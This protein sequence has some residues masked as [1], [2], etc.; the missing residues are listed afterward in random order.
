MSVG[1]SAAAAQLSAAPLPAPFYVEAGA[2]A[3]GP[4]MQAQSLSSLELAHHQGHHHGPKRHAR[5]ALGAIAE[6]LNMK[7][8]DLVAELRQGKSLAEVITAHGKSKA[9]AAKMIRT[10][11]QTRL[12]EAVKS[13]RLTQKQADE[14]LQK[15]DVERL[16]NTPWPAH[17]PSAAN[18]TA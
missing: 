6:W 5:A 1:G 12:Q 13:G 17:A 10:F 7:P 16:L 15:L 4:L 11:A 18:S 14:K 9:D 8:R 3:P 2:H